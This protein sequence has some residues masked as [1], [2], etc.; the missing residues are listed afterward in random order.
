MIRLYYIHKLKRRIKGKSFR[1][2]FKI[3]KIL[4][5]LSPKMRNDMVI[6]T[7]DGDKLKISPLL[8]K[9]IE[10]KLYN[11]GVYEEG[12]LYCFKKILKKGNVVLD[13]GAN[14]GLTAIRASKMIGPKGK[15][16]AI[17]AMPSTIEILKFNILLNKLKNV[18]CF[19]E[20]LADYIGKTNIFHNLE[21]K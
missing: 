4:T 19:N 2:K 8:D 17:E 5:R 12:T 13:V 21:I 9:G 18:I 6:K 14:I 3:E 11:Q 10:R 1:G 15:V 16:Y 20:A 7:I